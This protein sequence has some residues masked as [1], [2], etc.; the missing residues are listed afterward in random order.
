MVLSSELRRSEAGVGK[1]VFLI[2]PEKLPTME[3]GNGGWRS[4]Q[5][6]YNVPGR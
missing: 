2:L 5:I 6:A 1:I 3:M 4:G